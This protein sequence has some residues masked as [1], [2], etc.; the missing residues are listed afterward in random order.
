V[1]KVYK[2]KFFKRERTSLKLAAHGLDPLCGIIH[3]EI[4]QAALRKFYFFLPSY[5]R[6]SQIFLICAFLLTKEK[7]KI[8]CFPTIGSGKLTGIGL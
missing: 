3:Q 5:K 1:P 6:L 2:K 4:K 8:I 7:F